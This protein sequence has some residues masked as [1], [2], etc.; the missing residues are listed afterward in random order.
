MIFSWNE[1]LQLKFA[2]YS[3]NIAQVKRKRALGFKHSPPTE[4]VKCVNDLRLCAILNKSKKE[5]MKIC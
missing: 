5:N 2:V 4:K 3:E 1:Q